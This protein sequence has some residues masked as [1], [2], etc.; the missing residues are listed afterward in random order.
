[1]VHVWQL[2]EPVSA[3]A[4]EAIGKIAEFLTRHSGR[5]ESAAA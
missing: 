4:R 5:S 2:F 1:M 3:E